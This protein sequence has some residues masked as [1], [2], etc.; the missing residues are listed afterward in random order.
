LLKELFKEA[1]E[2]VNVELGLT[3]AARTEEW[4]PLASKR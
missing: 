1:F 3:L 4:M 2:I